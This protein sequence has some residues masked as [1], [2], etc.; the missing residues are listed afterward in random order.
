MSS[1]AVNNNPTFSSPVSRG[2]FAATIKKKLTAA[3]QALYSLAQTAK[4]KPELSTAT[5]FAGLSLIAGI[6]GSLL[7]AGIS[8]AGAMGIFIAS[9][10]SSN[11][12]SKTRV[13]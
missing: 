12:T 4:R 7:T 6:L 9:I 3:K 8:G 13:C 5:G 10:F 2:S 1:L 11:Q